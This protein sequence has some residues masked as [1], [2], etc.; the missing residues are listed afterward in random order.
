MECSSNRSKQQLMIKRLCKEL[1]GTLP[2][3]LNPHPGIPMRGNKDD[4]KVASLFFQPALQLQTGH[5]RHADI[6]DQASGLVM[7]VGFEEFFR[8]SE[9]TSGKPGRLHEVVE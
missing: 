2:H 4:W 6:N 8:R 3:C 7:Q 1:D 9:A 5:P